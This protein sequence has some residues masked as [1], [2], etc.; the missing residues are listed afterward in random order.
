MNLPT[1]NELRALLPYLNSQERAELD[2][3]LSAPT[4]WELL[5]GP[6]TQAANS[7]AFETLYGGSAGGGKSELLLWIARHR[8][9]NSLILRRSFPMLERHFIPKS[10]ERFGSPSQYNVSKHTWNLEDG[11]RIEFGF[12]DSQKDVYNYQGAEYDGFFPDE[13]TQIPRD[14]YLYIVSRIRT[15]RV[16]QRRRIIATTNPGGEYEGWVVERWA[17]WLDA[18][19]PNPAEPGEVRYFRVLPGDE[20]VEV[21]STPD[22][23]EAISRTFIRA[24]LSD[25][26][27]LTGSGYAQTLNMLP[28]PLRSQLRDGIW[29]IGSTD[30]SWQVIPTEWVRLAQARWK[31]SDRPDRAPDSIGV[32]VARGGQDKTVITPR[33]GSYFGRCAAYPGAKTPDGPA[34]AARIAQHDPPPDQNTVVNIDV[35]GPGGSVY[36]I[37]KERRTAV[38]LNSAA[39]STAKDKS[40]AL[41]FANKRAEWWW[42]FREM[43]DPQSGLDVAIPPDPEL[44]ADLCSA[45]WE[46]CIK[47]IKI[48]DKDE[49]KKRIGRSPDKGE[50]LLYA[51]VIPRT[52][53]VW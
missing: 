18:D 12:L 21:E 19:H 4:K 13:L 47:G 36:D 45:R 16:G 43:L 35:I 49:I 10:L 40:R 2:L 41:G 7:P 29:K 17:P 33:W 52:P 5:P 22:D 25:N 28:E 50:S 30:D 31:E 27:Y 14:W 6:Q 24:K 15:G 20:Y 8:H 46:P 53:K 11:C 37:E 39:G 1:Q 32:D 3:L 44:R 48:E 51:S 38:A 23:P 26:P 9:R 42:K 34:V